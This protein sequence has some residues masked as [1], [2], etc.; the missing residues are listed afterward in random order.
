MFVLFVPVNKILLGLRGHIF[1]CLVSFR[2]S[3]E[4]ALFSDAFKFD[5]SLSLK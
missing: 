4:K 1:I 5:F 2:P 3:V